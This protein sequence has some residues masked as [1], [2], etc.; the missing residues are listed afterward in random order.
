MGIVGWRVEWRGRG[1][2]RGRE[3]SREFGRWVSVPLWLDSLLS[4]CL[5]M[6]E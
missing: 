5:E 2:E 4:H 3:R 6:L 1:R